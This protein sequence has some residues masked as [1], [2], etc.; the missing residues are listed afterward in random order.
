[1]S[2]SAKSICHF[3]QMYKGLY[4]KH[5]CHKCDDISKHDDPDEDFMKKKSDG[6]LYC[7]Y[8]DEVVKT[9]EEIERTFKK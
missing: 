4:I 1:M 7:R 8:C 3:S 5:R 6:S 9:K 2:D